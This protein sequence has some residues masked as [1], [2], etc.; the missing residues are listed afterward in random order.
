MA[1]KWIMILLSNV[2]LMMKLLRKFPKILNLKN[3][4]DAIFAVNDLTATGVLKV[5]KRMG[6]RVPDD[7]SVAGF[8]DGLVATVTDPPLTTVSQHGFELGKKAAEILLDR[9]AS[10][11]EIKTP[12]HRGYSYNTRS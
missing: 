11:F 3:P 8:T 10:G 9:I 4:P 2:T 6:I 12:H 5:I 1:L 7:I